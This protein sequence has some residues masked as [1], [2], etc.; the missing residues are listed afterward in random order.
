M[1]CAGTSHYSSTKK[2]CIAFSFPAP[3]DSPERSLFTGCQK[4]SEEVA[5]YNE[6]HTIFYNYPREKKTLHHVSDIQIFI[7]VQ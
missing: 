6:P 4:S 1:D 7:T 2:P 5:V 3:H